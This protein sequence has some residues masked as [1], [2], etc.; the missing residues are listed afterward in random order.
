MKAFS[1]FIG[2]LPFAGKITLRQCFTA[3]YRSQTFSERLK[4][5]FILLGVLALWFFGHGMQVLMGIRLM[6]TENVPFWA[7]VAGA[8]YAVINFA[9]I[10]THIYLGIRATKFLFSNRYLRHTQ[11]AVS[12]MTNGEV[13][14]ALVTTLA[15]QFGFLAIYF[16]YV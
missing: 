13:L 11:H 15:G 2:K 5:Y 16:L 9:V 3:L 4:C 10:L 8:L 12:D 7:V 6:F 14:L 1:M